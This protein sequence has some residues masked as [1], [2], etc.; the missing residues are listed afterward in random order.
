M[1]ETLDIY[2]TAGTRTTSFGFSAC[3]AINLK[4]NV[5]NFMRRKSFEVFV[6]MLKHKVQDTYSSAW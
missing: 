3:G 2:C 6:K 5:Y 4:I 1:P